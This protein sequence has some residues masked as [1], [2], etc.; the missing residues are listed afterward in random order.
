MRNMFQLN[1]LPNLHNV[2][3]EI[4]FMLFHR[5]SAHRDWLFDF[6]KGQG[7]LSQSSLI[8]LRFASRLDYLD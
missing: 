4:S 6:E 7:T 2:L 1:S 8:A 5:L 3:S